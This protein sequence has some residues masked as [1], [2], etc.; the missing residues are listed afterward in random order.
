MKCL[1]SKRGRAHPTI[2]TSVHLCC[3]PWRLPCIHC[4]KTTHPLLADPAARR[5]SAAPSSPCS[6]ALN[7]PSHPFCVQLLFLWVEDTFPPGITGI[8]LVPIVYLCSQYLPGGGKWA[9]A[10]RCKIITLFFRLSG[11]SGATCSQYEEIRTRGSHLG[12]RSF[13]KC[14]HSR[15]RVGLGS[16][17]QWSKAHAQSVCWV[18]GPHKRWVGEGT[19]SWV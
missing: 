9:T 10:R 19:H 7:C 8:P 11:A 18:N 15:P 1:C 4:P 17:L 13:A 3:S 12:E 5:A 16:L 6:G 2:E 14:L